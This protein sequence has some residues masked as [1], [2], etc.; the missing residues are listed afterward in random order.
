MLRCLQASTRIDLMMHVSVV[1]IING[2]IHENGII[3]I[4]SP[5]LLNMSFHG[6]LNL[7]KLGQNLGWFGV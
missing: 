1:S 4:G 5:G 3:P 7:A 6:I 2:K